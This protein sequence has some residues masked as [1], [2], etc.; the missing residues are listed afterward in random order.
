[1]LHRT[2]LSF[3]SLGAFCVFVLDAPL[4]VVCQGRVACIVAHMLSRAPVLQV[5]ASLSSCILASVQ[6]HRTRV[7][8]MLC[9]HVS[10]SEFLLVHVS[11][12]EDGEEARARE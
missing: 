9:D 11:H 10:C 5:M 3:A 4:D 1:M 8:C 2:C 12:N 6:A 7:H